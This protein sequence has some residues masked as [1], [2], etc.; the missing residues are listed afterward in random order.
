MERA[1]V[2][3]QGW[4]GVLFRG[5][6]VELPGRKGVGKLESAVDGRYV[7]SVFYS[8]LRTETLNVALEGVDR[9]YL[10]RQTRVYVRQ[11]GAWKLA[12]HQQTPA[13]H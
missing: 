13:T 5:M 1:R 3:T 6:L 11:D 10:S 12:F 7:I 9:A 4:G 8:I 2:A